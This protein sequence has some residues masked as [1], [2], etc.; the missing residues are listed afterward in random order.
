MPV[1]SPSIVG[2][3]RASM[4]RCSSRSSNRLPDVR[5]STGQRRACRPG[6]HRRPRSIPGRRRAPPR[7]VDEPSRPS[8]RRVDRDAGSTVASIEHLRPL[9]HDPV[10]GSRPP[11]TSPRILRYRAMSGSDLTTSHGDGRKRQPTGRRRAD[12]GRVSFLRAV[13]DADGHS[14]ASTSSTA[15]TAR[16]RRRRPGRTGRCPPR[17]SAGSQPTI[18]MRSTVPPR[19]ASMPST[20]AGFM[21]CASTTG[22]G[23]SPCSARRPVRLEHGDRAR[24]LAHRHGVDE[25]ERVVAVEQLV[26]EVHAADAEV[27]DPHAVGDRPRRRAACTTSTP[28]PSSP[29]KMLP[30][31]A[32]STRGVTMRLRRRR[33][34]AARSRRDGSRGSG[35]A[36]SSASVAGRRRG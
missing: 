26:G 1:S 14:S 36:A 31:P 30:M 29:R 4:R 25:H 12:H 35:P 10:R 22:R 21:L 3:R 5:R 15:S 19:P 33:R 23:S 8:V 20:T 34:R 9:G 32:T 16:R 2:Y 18:R 17:A 6:L 13:G 24:R 27:L 28:K 7:R 11:A